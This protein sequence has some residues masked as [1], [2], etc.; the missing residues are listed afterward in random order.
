VNLAAGFLTGIA[1][2]LEE[3]E[4][5]LIIDKNVLTAVAAVLTW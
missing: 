3:Q 5:I 2:C 1:Q 4:P